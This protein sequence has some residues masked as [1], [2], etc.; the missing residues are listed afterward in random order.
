MF[1]KGITSALLA[2]AII[3]AVSIMF[4]LRGPDLSPWLHLKDPAI[5]TMPPQRVLE[6]EAKGS[7]ETVGKKAIGLLMK[8][9]F[10]MNGVPKKGSKVPAP[11][12]RWPQAASA[13]ITEWTDRY[14]MA[15]PDTVRDV[16]LP[17]AP[18]GLTVQLTTWEYGEVA[19][20]LY[21]G[22][23]DK[24]GPAVK[25]L[26][27][28]IKNSGY[29]IVGEH[30]EEYLRGPGMFFKGNPEKYVTVI[31]YRVRK[32]GSQVISRRYSYNSFASS[33]YPT[34]GA[35]ANDIRHSGS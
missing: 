30:E 9:Y 2:I 3:I 17:A 29:E 27:E 33:F 6:V 13:P 32:Q 20:I 18:K 24:E 23:Y 31:R 22:P 16:P 35:S 14:A 26:R 25:R 5:R 8:A 34:K 12:A 11:R 19:E 7:P 4:N 1:N 21:V 15:V 10:G 28:F